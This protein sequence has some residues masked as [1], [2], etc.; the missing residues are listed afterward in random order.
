[1]GLSPTAVRFSALGDIWSLLMFPQDYDIKSIIAAA[2]TIPLRGGTG[3][4]INFGCFNLSQP[5]ATAGQQP[6]ATLDAGAGVPR[7][8]SNKAGWK[9]ALTGGEQQRCSHRR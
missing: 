1:M 9:P 2:E 3:T 7:P 5:H 6:P 8:V 4:H